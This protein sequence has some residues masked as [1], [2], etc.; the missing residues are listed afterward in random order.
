MMLD[1]LRKQLLKPSQLM[2]IADN[3]NIPPDNTHPHHPQNSQ[4][5]HNHGGASLLGGGAM[6][7]QM[8]HRRTLSSSVGPE[9]TNGNNSSSGNNG[10]GSGLNS[11]QQVNVVK[12]KMRKCIRC[13]AISSITDEVAYVPSNPTT[14]TNPAFQHYQRVCFCG[15]SWANM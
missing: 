5:H 11:G 15:G 9:S 8:Q 3:S 1:T 10:S 13:G 12:L 2:E 7:M 6:A 4:L 14:T